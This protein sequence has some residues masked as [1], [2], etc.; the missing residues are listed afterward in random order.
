MEKQ[1]IPYRNPNQFFR[2]F[3]S[4][5]AVPLLSQAARSADGLYPEH[6]IFAIMRIE[7]FARHINFPINPARSTVYEFCW[8]KKGQMVRTDALQRFKIT[9]NMICFYAAGS[10]KAI[11]ACSE[12]AEGYYCIFDKDFILQFLKNQSTLDELPFFQADANPL[13]RLSAEESGG[14]Q[15]LLTQIEE[16]HL[17]DFG[18]KQRMIGV[19]LC[20]LLIQ[21]KRQYVSM[22]PSKSYSAPELIAAGFLQCVKL[23]ARQQ[24]SAAFYA[25]Q[26][27]ITANHLNKCVKECTG[28]PVTAHITDVLILEAKVLLKQSD[29]NIS[30]IAGIL[31]FEN[32]AYFARL[33]KKH[34]QFTPKSYR[35]KFIH[36][37]IE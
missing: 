31:G 34:T 30:E 28:K 26:L 5:E 21:M 15:Q 27:N 33:F 3:L 35:E 2:Q 25:G 9:A 11:E 14:V 23:N 7:D 37:V 1:N 19:L 22:P 20:Q 12:D 24:K 6:N 8:L 36:P 4:G 16:E 13:I 17:N 29:H 32:S 18:D 10:I